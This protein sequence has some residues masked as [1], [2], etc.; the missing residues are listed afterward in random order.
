MSVSVSV[1]S[2]SHTQGG[3]SPIVLSKLCDAYVRTIAPFSLSCPFVHIG[4]VPQ[5][6]I[7]EY[8]SV[9]CIMLASVH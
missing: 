9:Y 5:L 8:A 6:H 3:K 1:S 4:N 2:G 7:R